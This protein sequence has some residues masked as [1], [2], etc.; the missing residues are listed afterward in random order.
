MLRQELSWIQFPRSN[1]LLCLSRQEP[2]TWWKIFRGYFSLKVLQSMTF[3]SP[4]II[5][6]C[7]KRV[8]SGETLC[9]RSS[10]S[11]RTLTLGMRQNGSCLLNKCWGLLSFQ[12]PQK[13]SATST[14]WLARDQDSS[15]HWQRQMWLFWEVWQNCSLS[16]LIAIRL[17]RCRPV[18][19]RKTPTVSVKSTWTQGM[20]RDWGASSFWKPW[21]SILCLKARKLTFFLQEIVI[22]QKIKRQS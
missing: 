16:T 8:R 19:Q 13:Y 1:G 11:G 10:R 9:L 3:M 6:S 20:I 4:V 18:H 12:M 14:S 7:Y 21:N 15:K 5:S 2:E 22:P 17:K